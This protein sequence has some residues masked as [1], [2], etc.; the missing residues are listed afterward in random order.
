[1]KMGSLFFLL[2]LGALVPM[3][4]AQDLFRLPKGSQSRTFTFENPT[5]EKGAAAAT[6]HGAKG[7]AWE[8]IQAGETKTLLKFEGAGTVRRM[9]FTLRPFT[10]EMLRSLVIEMYWDHAAKPAVSVPFGD[11]FGQGL[12]QPVKGENEF[13]S[14]PEGRSFNCY[15]PMPFRTGAKIVVRNESKVDVGM[16]FYE[17]DMTQERT[18]PADMGYFHAYWSRDLR[19]ALGKDFEILPKVKGRGRYLGA[20]IGVQTPDEYLDSGWCEGEVKVFLDGDGQ[21]PTIAGTGTEDYVGTGWGMDVFHNRY[22]GCTVSDNKNRCW[23]YYRFH[24]PDPIVFE[25]DCRVTIQDIGGE[26]TAYVR[27][28]VE[29]GAELQPVPA[30]DGPAIRRL[31][32]DPTQ[33]KLEDPAFPLDAW[34]NFYRRDDF[35]AV[36]YFYLE[37]PTNDLPALAPLTQRIAGLRYK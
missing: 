37:R 9:W 32:S 7:N 30:A 5:G 6:N 23:A 10:Q 21:L 28:L 1:M 17:I 35:S 19:I 2:L 33:P 12:A 36:A 29:G 3:A 14:N 25:K 15:I 8:P 20:T 26:A 31:L 22:Q 27:K 18:Q 11:F 13:F 16:F 4:A 34:V 24:V